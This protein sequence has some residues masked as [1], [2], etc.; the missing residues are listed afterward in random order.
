MEPR[1]GPLSRTLLIL[2]TAFEPVGT[3]KGEGLR[4]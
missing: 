1:F 3:E 4:N 2:M